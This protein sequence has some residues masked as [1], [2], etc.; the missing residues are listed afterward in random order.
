MNTAPT[1]KV[2]ILYVAGCPHHAATVA[3]ARDVACTRGVASEVEEIE[4]RSLDDATR[5]RFLGSPS[6]RVDRCDIEPA[7]RSSAAYALAYRTYG[8]GGVPAAT[9]FA[10]ALDGGGAAATPPRG[11]WRHSLPAAAGG[12]ALL[13]PVGTCPACFPAYAAV[14]STLG[15]GFLLHERYL[16]PIASVLLTAALGGLAY[17][18]HTRRGYGPL[19][20]GTIGSAVALIGKFTLGSNPVLYLGLSM[21]AV[22]ATWNAWPHAATPS[23]CARCATR[24]AEAGPTQAQ[25]KT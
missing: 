25:K 18:A 19:V 16:L 8:A 20:A 22:A 13:L 7:A 5:L 11:G 4:V 12:A 17:R 14:L 24:E 15:V 10:A 21:L 23:S 2:E 9:L 3:R 6:V 1:R